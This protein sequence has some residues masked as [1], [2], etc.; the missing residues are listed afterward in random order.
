MHRPR[1]AEGEDRQP[2]R[3]AAA[4][5]GVHPR[6]AGHHLV[7]DLVDAPGGLLDAQPERLGHVAADGLPR[8]LDVERHRP[9]EEE[10]GIEVAED[11]IGIGDGRPLAAAAVAGRPGIG[12]RGVGPDLEQTE[13]VDAGDRA[14]AG[15]DLDHLDH[16]Q[17][18]RQPGALL[19][20][21][22]AVD[23]EAVRQQRLAAG[24]HRELGGGAPH[25]EGE[26][27]L[28]AGRGAEGRGGQRSPGGTALQQPDREA[29]GRLDRGQR[30][31]G[32]QH[33]QRAAES[34]PRQPLL[35]IAQVALDPGLDVDIGHGRRGALVLADLRRHVGRD[36]DADIGRGAPHG[37]PR[38]S[39]QLGVGE[40]V[41]EGDGDRLDPGRG[42]LAGQALDVLLVQIVPREG[43]AVG[44]GAPRHAEAELARHQGTR[45]LQLQVVEIVAMLAADLERIAESLAGQQRGRRALALDQR[46]GDQGRAVDDLPESRPSPRSRTPESPPARSRSR[47]RDHPESSASCR[48]RTRRSHRHRRRDR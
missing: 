9:A 26:Q 22:A 13:G 33:Q 47:P 36:R 27:I 29:S 23:L 8:R 1:A 24:D 21:V 31:G 32:D 2:P 30:A 7:D 40:A 15:A 3:I 44:E 38:A 4:L 10:A 18:D 25:I 42:Q 39:L 17:V 28:V 34:R 11:E 46:V 48:R 5:Q 20:A 12:A 35:Q 41:E 37:L 45:H 43:R 16:G 19:E 6:R 14:A